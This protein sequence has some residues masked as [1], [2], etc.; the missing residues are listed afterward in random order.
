MS[1]TKIGAL[2][3]VD[4]ARA[5]RMI[6]HALVESEGDRG[7]AAAQLETTLRTFYRLI[8][9]LDL[10][11]EIDR[12][13]ERKGF[14]KN[15]GPQRAEKKLRNLVIAADGN[16]EKAARSAGMSRE[17][18]EARI[19][20]LGLWEEIDRVLVAANLPPMEREWS[21]RRAALRR[22]ITAA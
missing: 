17:R 9:R 21:T 12:L 2:V 16:L 7:V 22:S 8:E 4:P 1:L 13:V 11:E 5:K 3:H 19:E 20:E 14:T 15:P 6:L 10:W 18:L